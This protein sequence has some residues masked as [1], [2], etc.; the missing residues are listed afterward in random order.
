MTEFWVSLKRK[1]G[2]VIRLEELE[3]GRDMKSAAGGTFSGSGDRIAICRCG[4]GFLGLE[5]IRVQ[6]RVEA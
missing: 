6:T 3:G 4:A 5:R 1:G 2:T